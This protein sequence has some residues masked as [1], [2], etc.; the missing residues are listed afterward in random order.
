MLDI[1]F[2][3]EN[4]EAIKIAAKNKN[5]TIDIDQ[6]LELDQKR[7]KLQSEIEDLRAKRN[8]IAASNKGGKPSP[9]QIEAGKKVKAEIAELGEKFKEVDKAY[10]EI[11]V[12]VPTIPSDDTPIGKSEDENV[13]VYRWE[14]PTKFDF[15]PKN[16]IEL[17]E[18]LDVIDFERGVKVATHVSNP[19][20]SHLS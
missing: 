5:I 10:D 18:N 9:E 1:K 13:E 7:G 4:A 12:R 6:L 11:M 8:E 15:E 14:E 3:R 20:P 17:A 2:I 16:H 19:D